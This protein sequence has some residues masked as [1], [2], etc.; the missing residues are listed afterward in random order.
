MRVSFPAPYEGRRLAVY[1]SSDPGKEVCLSLNA[2]AS[3]YA[4]S[5]VGA[6]A[7]VTFLV[8]RTADGKS[9][10][11]SIRERVTLMG[12]SPGMPD[13]PPFTM[14]VRLV[15]GTGSD[16][17]VF[18]YDESPLPEYRR[19]LEREAAKIAWRRYRQELYMDNDQEPFAVI[20]WLHTITAIYILWA[21][22]Y[23]QHRGRIGNGY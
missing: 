18:G 11:A 20:E 2:S 9:A 22:G 7:F 8:K 19:A 12:Q 3:E 15:N 23:S 17:Q 16:L 6:L 10:A 13:R 1:R 21:D 4:E 14:T 5:F